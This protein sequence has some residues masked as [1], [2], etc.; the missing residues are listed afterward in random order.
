[1]AAPSDPRYAV[2]LLVPAYD[3]LVRTIMVLRVLLKKR[4]R[5]TIPASAESLI[6]QTTINHAEIH[7]D[8]QCAPWPFP[9]LLM[10]FQSC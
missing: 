7:R 3:F 9:E 2:I 8:P 5:A 6:G 1:M 4:R 10:P